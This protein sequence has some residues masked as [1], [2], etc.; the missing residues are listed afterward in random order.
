MHIPI[1]VDYG[2]RAL[3]DLATHGGKRPI[4]TSEIANRQSIPEPYLAQVLH[5]L[6]QNGLT[7]SHRGPHGGHYLAIDP[8][9]ISMWLVMTYLGNPQPLVNCLDD[10]TKCSQSPTCGQRSVWQKVEEAINE[11]LENTTV[12]DLVKSSLNLKSNPSMSN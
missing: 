5:A 3:V 10:S 7:K 4:R 1:Q 2:V 11:V 9:E 6:Q 8:S 12:A